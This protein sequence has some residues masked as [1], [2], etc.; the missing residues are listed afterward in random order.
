MTNNS[1]I[2]LF[3]LLLLCAQASAEQDEWTLEK[4][5]AGIKVYTR[6]LQEWSVRQFRGVV[7]IEARIESLLALLDDETSCPR[8]IHNCISS[9][10]LEQ[11]DRYRKYYYVRNN[12]PWP[13]KKRDTILFN[14]TT[15]TED[16]IEIIGIAEPGYR[17][18]DKKFVRI[19]KQE[20][21]WK[22]MPTENGNVQV[23]F[24]TKF[25]PGGSVP[26]WAVNRTLIETPFN[27]L[28]KMREVVQEPK[29]RDT[30]MK[31]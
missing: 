25:D 2:Y 16:H 19:P 20:V 8:W 12:A 4:D 26:K 31:P 6:S 9:E 7:E 10:L 18:P 21:R 13:V 30:A 14:T 11:P 15:V 24:E 28:R 23:T 29:Y 3:L 27:T 5:E 1:R 22:L 17:P